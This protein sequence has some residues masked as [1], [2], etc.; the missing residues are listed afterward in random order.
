VSSLVGDPAA[1][2]AVEQPEHRGFRHSLLVSTRGVLLGAAAGAWA[3]LLIGGIGGRVAM[4]VLRVTS[5]DAVRRRISDDGF[6]I[7]QV[8]GAT[9]FL[10]A[11]TTALGAMAGMVYIALRHALPDPWRRWAWTIVGTTVGGSALLHADGVDFNL[12]KPTVLAVAMFI[13]IP[14][15]GAALMAVWVERWDAWWFTD[16]RRTVVAVLPALILVPLIFP[17]LVAVA[18]VILVSTAAQS[19]HVR[20]AVRVIGPPVGR[21]A[22][23]IVAALSSWALFNDIT[24][25]L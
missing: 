15:G 5:P 20:T 10:L 3:G 22:L 18:L 1:A 23:A 4:G 17:L 2:A 9:L 19:S 6:E 13:A 21:V 11:I 25:I 7:G 12:L 16:R 24:E 8:S 14:A